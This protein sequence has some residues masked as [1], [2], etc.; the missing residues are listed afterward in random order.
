MRLEVRKK[1]SLGV[2]IRTTYYITYRAWFCLLTSLAKAASHFPSLSDF[3]AFRL[4]LL[5]VRC[6][7]S[8]TTSDLTAGLR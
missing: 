1:T 2:G 8:T 6:A 4:V 7:V 3:L 5:S